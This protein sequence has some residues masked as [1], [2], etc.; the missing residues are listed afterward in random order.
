M[1]R[2]ANSTALSVLLLALAAL[3]TVASGRALR[4]PSGPRLRVRAVA[5]AVDDVAPA[6]KNATETALSD[7]QRIIARYSD[8]LIAVAIRKCFVALYA[9]HPVVTPPSP[10]TTDG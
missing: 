3:A 8:V 10:S 4:T 1:A 5:H 7:A 9:I 6:L 2:L